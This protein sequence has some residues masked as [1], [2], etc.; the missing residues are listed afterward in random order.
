[1]RWRSSVLLP[2]PLPPIMMKISPG[3]MLK[4]RSRWITKL[5]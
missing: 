3:W 1:M 4:V 2:H 5:P